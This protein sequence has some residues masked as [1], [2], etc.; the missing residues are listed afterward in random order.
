MSPVRSLD[1]LD[2]LS[3]R[4]YRL[5]VARR[6]HHLGLLV[7][8]ASLA[9]GPAYAAD[10]TRV[11]TAVEPGEPL[12]EIRIGAH[13]EHDRTSA[14]ISRE[15]I[16]DANGT[17]E[18]TDVRELNY[19]RYIHR[20]MLDVRVGV[21]RDLELHIGAP[22]ILQD[23]SNISFQ[24]GV[25]GLSSIWDDV[26]GS[27]ANNPADPLAYPLTDVPQERSRAGFGDMRFGIGWSP[28]VD[29]KDEAYPTITLRG[30]II[31]P[32][33][34]RRDPADVNAR[35]D[36]PGR[37]GVGLGQ[38]VFDLSLGMSRKMRFNTPTLDPYMIFGV[39]L[40]VAN[41]AQKDAGL[42]PPIT[43]RFQVGSEVVFF[44]QRK[45]RVRYAVDVSFG[46]QYISLGRTYS[47]LSD[48]LPNFNQRSIPGEPE[49]QDFAN[50]A[51][52][53]VN[54]PGARC[55]ILNGVPCGELNRVDEHL[56][57]KGKLTFH[58]QPSRWILLQAGFS[59]GFT[60]PHLITGE[61]VGDD[62][63]PAGTNALCPVSN[64]S[65]PCAGR[66]NASNSQGV[67]ERSQYYDPRYD[68]PGR[69]L[70]VEEVLDLSFFAGASFTF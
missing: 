9:G 28:T 63:D 67:D 5:G 69:R 12:P 18:S 70:R 34:S 45:E 11:L 16:R 65:G 61:K 1:S 50:A 40:P 47:E 39:R 68:V 14:K 37:G 24:E 52:Y 22:I 33:G 3:G 31:A 32:T 58:L 20:L 46:L 2:S 29:H 62:L 43:A 27:R 60:T 10:A 59:V 15:F 48:Y 64:P 23:H 66:V 42:Q 21:F 35:T 54:V 49:Y 30:D 6:P 53:N 44:E 7:L 57:M 41:A 17:R 51:N 13:F 25:A 36:T 8:A 4:G 55:G 26:L 56:K 38:T 19:R